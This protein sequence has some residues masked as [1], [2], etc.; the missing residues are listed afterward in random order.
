MQNAKW[1][2]ESPI[3]PLFICHFAFCILHFAFPFLEQR[4]TRRFATSEPYWFNRTRQRRD[5]ILAIF[6]IRSADRLL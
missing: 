3:R 5:Y 4:P 2:M 1:Q 6:R